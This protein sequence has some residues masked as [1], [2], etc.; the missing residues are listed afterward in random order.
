MRSREIARRYASALYAV[1]V[2]EGVVSKTEEEFRD[3]VDEIRGIDGFGRFL[4]HPLI[5]RDKKGDLIVGA[6]P[7][8][9]VYLA[10]TVSLLIRHRR[11]GYIDLIY[12]EFLEARVK[13][14]NRVRVR[15]VTAV[16]LSEKDRRQLAERLQ[17]ALGRVVDLQ[18]RVDERLL[19][20]AR[21]EV[22]G[23]TID[24]TLRARLSELR[25]SLER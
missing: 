12:D 19:A 21:I 3:V 1:A 15:V 14:E 23:K 18:D 5:S 2:E 9:S 8:L 24:A 6:F 20:G 16:E 11:E 17:E 25:I 22:E 13:A 4:T 7:D 10:N